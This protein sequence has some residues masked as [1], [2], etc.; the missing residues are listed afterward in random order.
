MCSLILA[1]SSVRWN[2][3]RHPGRLTGNQKRASDSEADDAI[4]LYFT[5]GKVMSD[6]SDGM[7]SLPFSETYRIRIISSKYQC[8]L[9]PR[10]FLL[11]LGE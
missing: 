8:L 9:S 1:H 3:A 5:L 11:P 7:G 10:H 6:V 4:P 2:E